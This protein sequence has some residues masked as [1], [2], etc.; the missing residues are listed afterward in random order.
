MINKQIKKFKN[1]KI[2]HFSNKSNLKS[3][4]K[5]L[6]YCLI[7]Y[8]HRQLKTM[9][10]RINIKMLKINKPNRIQYPKMK[11]RKYKTINKIKITILTTQ[12]I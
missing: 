2:S 4:Q 10:T 3:N 12:I 8:N 5:N 6:N 9:K 1:K 11:F 7:V